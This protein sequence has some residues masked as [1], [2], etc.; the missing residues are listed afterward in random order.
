MKPFQERNY[1]KIPP[2]EE[3]KR[4]IDISIITLTFLAISNTLTVIEPTA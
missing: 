1:L 4:I 3:S 2:I